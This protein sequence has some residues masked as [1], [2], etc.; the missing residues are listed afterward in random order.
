[1]K[2]GKKLIAL[3]AALVILTGAALA[4]TL[5]NPERQ[6]GSGQEEEKISIFTLDS[7]S[8]TALSW[9]YEEETLSFLCDGGQ[10]SYADDAAFPLDS[11]YLEDMVTALGDVTAS[12]SISEPEDLAQYGLEEPT[13]T[14]TVST[15]E[16]RE[17]RIG[18][19]TSLD[20]LRYCS[21]GDGN[22]YLVDSALLDAFSY[23]L[24]DLVQME[25]IPDIDSTDSFT[26]SSGT[27]T[28]TIVYRED[29][30]LAYSDDYVWFLQNGGEY[31]ALDTEQ[32]ESLLDAVT[33]LTW[34]SC[35]DYHAEASELAD[36]GLDAPAATVTVQYQESVQV[37]TGE[38]DEEGEPVYETQERDAQFIL[39]VGDSVDDACYARIAGSDM[40]YQ[41][42]GSVRDALLYTTQSELLPDEVLLMDWDTVD[43]IDI[44]L[45]GAT[46]HVERS[47]TEETD[48][49]GNTSEKTIYTLN[50]SEIA[51]EDILDD[52]TALSS[53]G[54]GENLTPQRDAEIRF[55]F[56]RNTE[57]F[58]EVELTFYQY[59]STS[60]LVGLN[61]ET[62]LFV[63]RDDI[64]SLAEAVRDLVL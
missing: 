54:S 22:V 45:D 47:T 3:L 4:A 13:C 24:S 7:D 33:A 16:D 46:Y 5:L 36:Y 62:R 53:T 44:T 25:T 15:G 29:S 1:M 57:S 38:T 41:I 14:V 55:L 23:G 60:C 50:G 2:R 40:V 34:N 52:L 19:A 11:S 6:E 26:V 9:T 64:V 56:H 30:G 48:D 61:G 39:E 59:D 51:I 37:E 20:G 18:D 17:L 12:K 8:V 35:A 32:T 58:S 21:T 28:Y 63:S 43:S 49:D 31:T 10:W 27:G 42:D